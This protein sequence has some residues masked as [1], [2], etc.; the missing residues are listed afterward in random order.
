MPTTVLRAPPCDGPD[1][2]LLMADMKNVYDDLIIINLYQIHFCRMGENCFQN[3]LMD[4]WKKI[5]VDTT[6][7]FPKFQP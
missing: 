3:V 1:V 4:A 2:K 7:Y 5:G 6:L